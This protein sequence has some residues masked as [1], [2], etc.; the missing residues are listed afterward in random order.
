MISVRARCRRGPQYPV[1]DANNTKVDTTRHSE[2]ALFTPPPK[3]TVATRPKQRP[4][5]P[6]L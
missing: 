3:C 5:L 6:R 4:R 1:A 2:T